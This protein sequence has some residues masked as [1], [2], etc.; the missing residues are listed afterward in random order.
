MNQLLQAAVYAVGGGLSAFGA[1][2]LAF[3]VALFCDAG[4]STLDYFLYGGLLFTLVMVFV[5]AGY[6]LGKVEA[7]HARGN[8]MK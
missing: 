1:A 4:P 2:V 8:F 6:G 5:S 7:D 3:F